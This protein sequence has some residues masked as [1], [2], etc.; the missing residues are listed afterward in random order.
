MWSAD[1]ISLDRN[2]LQNL[3]DK[4]MEELEARLLTGALWDE[5][6][7]QRKKLSEISL[8]IYN[9]LSARSGN[10]AEKPGRSTPPST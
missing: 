2:L 3:Y 8:M 5:V 10:P 1:L 7:E 9:K 4:E 6:S